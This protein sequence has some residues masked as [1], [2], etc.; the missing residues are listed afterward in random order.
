MTNPIVDKIHDKIQ[1]ELHHNNDEEGQDYDDIQSFDEQFKYS[2]GIT[3]NPNEVS[4]TGFMF[5]FTELILAF[6]FLIAFA[7]KPKKHRIFTPE[8]KKRVL[9]GKIRGVR[10]VELIQI[11]GILTIL[12]VEQITL[13][14]IVKHFVQIVIG[15]KQL[16]KQDKVKNVN[17]N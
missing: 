13:Q 3:S 4:G 12:E 16:E 9:T 10:Y 11:I 1:H 6:I 8:T 5:L 15:I 14:R 7:P 17:K 2:I